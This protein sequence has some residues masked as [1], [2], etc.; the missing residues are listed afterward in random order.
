MTEHDSPHVRLETR[1]GVR[2]IVFDRPDKKNALTLD[3]YAATAAALRAA[4]EDPAIRVVVLTG[5]G[6]TF[7]AGNDLA[8]F[9]KNPPTSTDTPVFAFLEELLR[10]RKPLIA[11]VCGAAVGIGTTLLLHCDLV[12]AG[13]SAVFRMPFVDLGVCPEAGSSFLLP[14]I[15]G[16]ARAAELLLLGE[17][18][19]ADK[20]L[21]LGLVT[22]VTADDN[23]HELV[24][25]RAATLA[26]KPPGAVRLT[27][28]LLKRGHRAAVRQAMEDEGAEFLVRL[29]SPEAAEAFRAFFERRPP[30][31]SAFE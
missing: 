14:R 29:R 10:A 26:K 16:Q 9:Q 8:D 28:E 30:D 3:M 11:A 7:T 18:F 13:R 15:L 24:A 1:D 12:Y 31:F 25:E 6:G 22:A 21:A 19:E 5:S 23:L 27:K 2:T 20:A 17:R 4:D